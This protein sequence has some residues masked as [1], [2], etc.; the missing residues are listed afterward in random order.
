MA[1]AP[2]IPMDFWRGRE[3]AVTGATGF[4]GHHLAWQLAER[5]ARVRALVRATSRRDHLA[6][7]GIRCF[8]APLDDAPALVRA[9]TGCE[10]LFHLAGAVDFES[11]WERFQRINVEGTR[12]VL[13]AARAAGVRRVVHCSSI[14]AVG[15]SETARSINE[16]ADWNLGPLRV[17]YVT[18]KRQAEE[19][20]LEA[21]ARSLEVVVVNPASVVGPDDFAGSEFGT[22]CK[23]FWRGRIPFHFGGGN[24]YVDVRD[25]AEGHL[26]AAERG[27][28][29]QRYLLGGTNRTYT[30]F[31][32]E[33]ARVA[34][35]SIF[36][37]QVPAALGKA[38]AALTD[39]FK[40]KR[41]ARSYLTPGQARLMSYYFF[42]DCGK[43]RRELSYEPRNLRDSL[44]DAFAFWMKKSA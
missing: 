41:D 14:V 16:T 29:G 30:A 10:F 40:R 39:R 32:S 35:R 19:L 13:W 5:G 15:A 27:R 12:N 4:V 20:A 1:Q 8:E 23:R 17:P 36:R 25:V 9:C 26:L 22:L 42:F 34:G 24:N 33:L 3:V 37:V 7:A 18:T 28:P 43:A 21:N 38:V 11:D 31:F 44:T 2:H 6:A